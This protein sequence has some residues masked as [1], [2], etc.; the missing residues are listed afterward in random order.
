M[1]GA[2]EHDSQEEAAVNSNQDHVY[3]LS[4]RSSP[5]LSRSAQLK[6]HPPT[7][8]KSKSSLQQ[9][10]ADDEGSEGKKMRGNF[11]L[12]RKLAL[13]HCIKYKDIA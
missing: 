10:N 5:S 8:P 1:P 6:P 9:A 7:S 12:L 11:E 13:T 4:S 2:E 3:A